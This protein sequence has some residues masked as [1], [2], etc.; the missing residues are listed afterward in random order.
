MLDG[1][2]PVKAEIGKGASSE[3][4]ADKSYPYNPSEQEPEDKNND[5]YQVSYQKEQNIKKDDS[6]SYS[7]DEF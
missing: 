3:E 7:E 1:S 2:V 5:S 6:D 4:D